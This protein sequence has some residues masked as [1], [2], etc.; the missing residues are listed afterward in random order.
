MKKKDTFTVVLIFL[1][2][3]ALAVLFICSKE[4]L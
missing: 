1:A 4:I 2:I 3:L